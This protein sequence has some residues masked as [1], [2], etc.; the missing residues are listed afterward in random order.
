MDGERTLVRPPNP[1][2]K[3]PHLKFGGTEILTC[4]MEVCEQ[5][6]FEN[7]VFLGSRGCGQGPGADAVPLHKSPPPSAGANLLLDGGAGPDGA[8]SLEAS[9]SPP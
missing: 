8:G 7:L 9:V 3:I 5:T 6:L 1:P 2:H 4:R